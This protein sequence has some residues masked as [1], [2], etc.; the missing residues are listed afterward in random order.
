[1]VAEGT[2]PVAVC[3]RRRHCWSL[4]VSVSSYP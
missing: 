4:I 2:A 1:M 3:C